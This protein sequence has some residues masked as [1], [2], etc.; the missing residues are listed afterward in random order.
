MNVST[1]SLL[2]SLISLYYDLA[3]LQ[4]AQFGGTRFAL[5]PTYLVALDPFKLEASE[6]RCCQV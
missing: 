6:N 4:G 3:R 2:S 5:N 1:P